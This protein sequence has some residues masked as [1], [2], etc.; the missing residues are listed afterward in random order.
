MKN[1]K[2]INGYAININGYAIN[3]VNKRYEITAAGDNY[4]LQIE[5]TEDLACLWTYAELYRVMKEDYKQ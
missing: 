1:K 3:C 5:P 2:G 4:V